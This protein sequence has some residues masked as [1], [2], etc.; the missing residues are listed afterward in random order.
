VHRSIWF[1]RHLHSARPLRLLRE[2]TAGPVAPGDVVVEW[3]DEPAAA[4]G[5]LCAG[6]LGSACAVLRADGGW[7]AR[8]EGTGAVVWIPFGTGPIVVHPDLDAEP[9]SGRAA[10]DAL[11]TGVLTRLPFRWGALPLHA[12]TLRTPAGLVLLSGRSGWGKSTLAHRL[13]VDAGWALL[14]DD[15]ACA[16]LDGPEPRVVPMGG[17]PR[18]RADAL[19]AAGAAGESLSGFA[20][21]KHALG[22][23]AD[24]DVRP[25]V[26]A[27]V[28]AVCHLAPRT[29]AAGEPPHLERLDV[30][31]AVRAAATIPIGL[32]RGARWWVEARFRAGVAWASG[33]N[34]VVR[35]TPGDHRPH[36][37]AALVAGAVDAGGE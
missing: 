9:G 34:L 28:V 29:L 8:L 31:A 13:S 25:A 19:A 15:A 4:T 3:S 5:Q 37:V 7:W 33:R 32:D 16:V 30:P 23:A 2:T 24:G 1:D 27:A 21:G 20:G 10:G 35:Y 14:D 36:D 26:P 17:R 11:V 18:L 22:W 12:A 6:E